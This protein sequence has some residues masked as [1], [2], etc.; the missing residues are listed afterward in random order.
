MIC[1]LVNQSCD[2]VQTATKPT[3]VNTFGSKFTFQATL[4]DKKQNKP[5]KLHREPVPQPI[6]Q[7]TKKPTNDPKSTSKTKAT[8]TALTGPKKVESR[9]TLSLEVVAPVLVK[10][11]EFSANLFVKYDDKF[12][13]ND[14]LNSEMSKLELDDDVSKRVK[15][16]TGCDSKVPAKNSSYRKSKSGVYTINMQSSILEFDEDNS[17]MFKLPPVPV[18][19]SCLARPV[20]EQAVSSSLD[21]F[22]QSPQQTPGPVAE[23]PS[24]LRPSE[25]S[26]F[27]DQIV[28]VETVVIDAKDQNADDEVYVLDGERR[29]VKFYRNLIIIETKNLNDIS[30]IWESRISE[31]PEDG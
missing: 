9:G 5:I 17:D 8:S 15:W 25:N 13:E 24:C 30:S 18:F 3:N 4:Y 19:D 10:Y 28:S 1:F 31:A 7:A 20:V 12:Y 14:P 21:G 22:T 16:S 6:R 26:I 27:T 2:Q 23:K 29:D 11:E